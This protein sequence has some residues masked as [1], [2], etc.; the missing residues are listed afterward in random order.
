MIVILFERERE[1][2]S[3]FLSSFDY[4]LKEKYQFVNVHLSCNN[5]REEWKK[6]TEQNNKAKVMFQI[7]LLDAKRGKREKVKK[8]YFKEEKDDVNTE[9]HKQ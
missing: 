8:Q 9:S 2:E 5:V 7:R 6:I 3:D 1:R 4:D